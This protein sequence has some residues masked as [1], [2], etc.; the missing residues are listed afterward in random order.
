[1]ASEAKI[2]APLQ[3]LI[4]EDTDTDYLLLERKVEKLLAPIACA[5]AADRTQLTDLLLRHWDI[6]ISDYHL[7][8]IEGE[9]LLAL[10][11]QHHRHTPCL[12]LSGSIESFEGMKFPAH[13]FACVEK[14]DN[15]AL[16]DALLG[17]W[18]TDYE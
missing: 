5:R 6:I 15:A 18:R 2:T 16:R 9:H 8:D 4:V 10:I 17:G 1:M 11:E 3:V 7:P 14:G 12:L 13:V